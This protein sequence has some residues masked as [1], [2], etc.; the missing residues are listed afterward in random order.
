MPYLLDTSALSEP[1]R[2]VP[3]PAF[4]ERLARVASADILTST[5]CVMEL[6][7]GAALRSDAGLWTRITEDVLS[8]IRVIAFGE[9]EALRCGM[10][11]AELSRAGTPIGV[12]DSQIGATALVHG[13]AVVTFNRKHFDRIPGLAV[14]DWR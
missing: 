8:G 3:N 7:F 12:E 4:M 9:D 11:L 2:R 5:V 13:L 10:L 6:R 14:E 1:L